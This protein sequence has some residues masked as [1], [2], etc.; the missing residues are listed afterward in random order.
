MKFI[1]LGALMFICIFIGYIISLKYSRRAKFFKTIVM[2]CQKLNVEINFSRERLKAL[3]LSF[4]EKT[5]KQLASLDKN[6]IEYLENNSQLT[7][8]NLFKGITF[9]KQNEKDLL[10][11]FFKSLGRSDLASQS[12]ELSNYEKRFTEFSELSS[13]EN[14]KFGSLSIK[15]GIIAGL[16]VVVLFC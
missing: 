11:L 5:Q 15:L 7:E 16:V 1:L 3:F 13:S 14:K 6:Y 10:L 12:Q 8:E 2:L 9:L 4:D